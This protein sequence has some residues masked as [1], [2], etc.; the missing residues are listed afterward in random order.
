[1]KIF[2]GKAFSLCEGFPFACASL[3]HLILR[4]HWLVIFDSMIPYIFFNKCKIS[5]ILLF[6]PLFFLSANCLNYCYLWKK[7]E[8]SF[9]LPTFRKIKF[10]FTPSVYFSG[11]WACMIQI[12]RKI[13]YCFIFKI[14]DGDANAF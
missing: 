2:Y 1:M 4:A 7:F 10:F 9:F 6:F 12:R 3:F 5:L 14:F 11:T 13:L 8:V